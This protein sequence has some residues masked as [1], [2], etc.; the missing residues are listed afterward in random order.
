MDWNEDGKK[1]LITGE[2]NGFIQIYLNVNTDEDPRF[3]IFTYLRVNGSPYVAGKYS[4]PFIVDWN[5]DGK[6]DLLCGNLDGLVIL[7]INE[8]TNADPIFNIEKTV[9]EQ[10]IP[11]PVDIDVGA[12][13]C[14]VSFDLNRDGKKDLVV[15]ESEGYLYYYENTGTDASPL[16][17]GSVLLEAGGSVIDVYRYSRPFPADWKDDGVIDILCGSSDWSGPM[18]FG[19]Y[20]FECVGPLALD[21]NTVSVGTGGTV[22]LDLDAGAENAGRTYYLLGGVTGTDPGTPLPGGHAVLHLNWDPFTDIVLGLINTPL[23]DNFMG[24]LN[25]TGQA[26]AV[27]NVPAVPSALGLVMSYAYALNNPWDF[28]S[29]GA[30]IVFVP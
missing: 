23:F 29:N 20:Y 8:G 12:V 16:F 27:L 24:A 25:G 5:N 2:Y 1:D 6:K 30:G 22:N 28:A 7:L 4:I 15:G 9:K 10:A 21:G 11:F 19:V 18:L 17:D 26:T 14:P 13:S 3:D